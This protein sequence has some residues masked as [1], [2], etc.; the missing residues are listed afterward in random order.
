MIQA[1]KEAIMGQYAMSGIAG[2]SAQRA[3]LTRLS[4]SL[5][6][7]E[8]ILEFTADRVNSIE[9]RLG[10]ILYPTQDAKQPSNLSPASADQCEINNRMSHYCYRLNLLGQQIDDLI[11]RLAL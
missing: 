1:G 11:N 10:P 3:S 2:Q 4:D 7:L 5:D 9:N 8:K 6:Q